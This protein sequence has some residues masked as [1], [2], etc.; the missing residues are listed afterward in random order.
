MAQY[1]GIYRCIVQHGNDW[2]QLDRNKSLC[3]PSSSLPPAR[4][5]AAARDICSW[6]SIASRAL[7]HIISSLFPSVRTVPWIEIDQDPWKV[8]LNVNHAKQVCSIYIIGSWSGSIKINCSTKMYIYVW[9]DYLCLLVDKK[10]HGFQEVLYIT[11]MLCALAYSSSSLSQ[12][13]YFK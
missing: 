10:G 1:L 2:F 8:R 12:S 9:C 5:S 4:F 7:S 13:S 3:R 6:R 11:L